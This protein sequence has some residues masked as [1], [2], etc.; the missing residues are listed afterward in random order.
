MP[1]KFSRKK[2]IK[3]VRKKTPIVSPVKA[4]KAVAAVAGSVKARYSPSSSLE[5]EDDDD[6]NMEDD[7]NSE[8]VHST[9]AKK[10]QFAN[11]VLRPMSE[12]I[13]ESLDAVE[14][15]P[16]FIRS[17]T[18]PLSD[19]I[20]FTSDM[21]YEISPKWIDPM[22][23]HYGCA[24]AFLLRDINRL[25]KETVEHLADYHPDGQSKFEITTIAWNVNIDV[26]PHTEHIK[27]CKTM[28]ETLNEQ[29]AQVLDPFKCNDSVILQVNKQLD[30]MS[31]SIFVIGSVM[32]ELYKEAVFAKKKQRFLVPKRKSEAVAESEEES[33]DDD[34][35][36]DAHGI[37]KSV[38][39][40]SE[41]L[42]SELKSYQKK[43]KTSK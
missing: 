10:I 40:S 31:P 30:C 1:P 32:E 19:D 21:F 35:E 17:V 43:R 11:S 3:A 9:Q 22:N 14:C 34:E 39:S 37:R 23:A 7:S 16:P 5:E 29:T 26:Y 25:L 41:E 8:E 12:S 13:D 33:D 24:T 38:S 6:E 18:E 2:T 42:P 15:V 28:V 36:K 20:S 4:V 27:L